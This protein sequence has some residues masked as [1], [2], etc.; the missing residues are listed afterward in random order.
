M[1]VHASSVGGRSAGHAD[2]NPAWK[3]HAARANAGSSNALRQAGTGVRQAPRPVHATSSALS[4]KPSV[5]SQS[6]STPARP[7]P[8]GGQTSRRI[9]TCRCAKA[10]DAK[11][12]ASTTIRIT[13][14]QNDGACQPD[15]PSGSSTPSA[16][17]ASSAAGARSVCHSQAQIATSAST[18]PAIVPPTCLTVISRKKAAVPIA[19]N[20]GQR[21]SPA[22]T[23]TRSGWARAGLVIKVSRPPVTVPGSQCAPAS[24]S[25]CSS[26]RCHSGS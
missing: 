23:T 10:I 17:C 8:G 12:V 15:A 1:P 16:A 22:S 19:A 20:K 6:A 5:C 7:T 21:L 13:T 26:G 25:S 24:T 11:I 2:F 9:A 18:P 3:A 14:P 4:A